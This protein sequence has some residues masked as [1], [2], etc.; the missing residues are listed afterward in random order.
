MQFSRILLNWMLFNIKILHRH[1][2]FPSVN[3][4]CLG[5][6]VVLWT[7]VFVAM[8][9]LTPWSTVLLEKLTGSAASQEIPRLFGTR[10]L[11]TVPTSARHV[12]LSWAN[13]IQSPQL[14]PT[15]WRSMLIL[16]SHLRLGL[17]NGLQITIDKNMRTVLYFHRNQ[18]TLGNV[19]IIKPIQSISGS[20]T[21]STGRSISRIFTAY[22]RKTSN[23]TC[24]L[25]GCMFWILCYL[26]FYSFNWPTFSLFCSIIQIS[27]YSIYIRCVFMF[28]QLIYRTPRTYYFTALGF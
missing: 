11:L 18:N 10:R 23:S 26:V 7:Y 6:T 17:L 25:S 15:S 14:P 21:C 22:D 4:Y 2:R 24:T 13:S 1:Q 5:R 28:P 19:D 8:S 3:S 16:S 9:L 20:S 27:S 12:S